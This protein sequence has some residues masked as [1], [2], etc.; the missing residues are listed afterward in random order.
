MPFETR[1][2]LK[3]LFTI[4]DSVGAV[5]NDKYLSVDK[6]IIDIIDKELF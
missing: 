2:N 6:L 5:A 3:L 1:R 4:A